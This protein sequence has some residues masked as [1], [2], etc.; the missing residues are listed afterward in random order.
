MVGRSLIPLLANAG[1][2]V[3]AFSRQRQIVGQSAGQGARVAFRLLEENDC[4]HADSCVAQAKITHW[5]CLA[6]IWVLPDYFA[7]LA[8]HQAKRVVAL[9]STSIFTKKRSSDPAE[10]S[11]AEKLRSGEQRFIAWAEAN[12]IEWVILRPTMIYGLGQD[13]NICEIARFISRFGFFPLFGAAQGLRQPVHVEDVA[14]ACAAALQS[15]RAANHSYNLSGAEVLSYREMAGRIFRLLDKPER[16]VAVPLVIFRL[17]IMCLRVW[18]GFRNWSAAMAERMNFDLVFDHADATRDL[19]FSP[20]PFRPGKTDL[21][22]S[23]TADSG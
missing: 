1:W 12:R 18:P 9:G 16:F 6:P 8:A 15:S 3:E 14:A 22:V 23:E 20:K 19:G 11:T 7:M 13:R 4:G 2:H 10:Q 21:P 17:A 5:V